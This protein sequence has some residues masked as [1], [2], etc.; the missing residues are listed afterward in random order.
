MRDSSRARRS[1][2]RKAHLLE[3]RGIAGI[4]A[5]LAQHRIDLDEAEAAV[6]LLECALQ[7]LER[8]LLVAAP[9]VAGRDLIRGV[10]GVLGRELVESLLRLLRPAEL[11]VRERGAL[12]AKAPVA[13]ALRR[14]QRLRR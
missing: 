5:D 12:K 3:Q 6:V 13:G 9:G 10:V 7:P 2:A 4:A 14:L 1:V 8:S 11:V